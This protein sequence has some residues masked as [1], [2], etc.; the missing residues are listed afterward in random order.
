MAGVESDD[1]VAAWSPDAAG[2]K[3]SSGVVERTL[4]IVEDDPA[5]G[6]TLERALGNERYRCVRATTM[7]QARAV[8]SRPSL[9][10][11]DLGLPDGDGLELAREMTS[12][13]PGIPIVVLTGRAREID[14]VAGLD[15]G[16]IDY[17]T[18]PFRLLELLTRVRTHLREGTGRRVGRAGERRQVQFDE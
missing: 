18:K 17:V 6:S 13:W 9:V 10:L 2:W 8:S 5:T 11:L 16:A 7:A 12:R 14:V 4:L 3:G 15:A 1:D